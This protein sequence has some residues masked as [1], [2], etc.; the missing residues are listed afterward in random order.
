METENDMDKAYGFE[1]KGDEAYKQREFGDEDAKE[2]KDTKLEEQKDYYQRPKVS[3][4]DMGKESQK[5]YENDRQIRE[6]IAKHELVK[7][8]EL[9][10]QPRR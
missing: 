9:P 3:K 4:D 7:K 5:E 10:K 2:A 1:V 6:R 8:N